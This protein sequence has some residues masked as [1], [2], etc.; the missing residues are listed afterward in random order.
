LGSMLLRETAH[1]G[2]HGGDL[3]RCMKPTSPTDD[4]LR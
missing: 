3:L 1:C 4:G 2:H